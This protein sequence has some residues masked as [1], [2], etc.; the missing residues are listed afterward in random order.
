MGYTLSWKCKQKFMHTQT[1]AIDNS[2]SIYFR[3]QRNMLILTI[4]FWLWI[5]EFSFVYNHKKIVSAIIFFQ[6]KRKIKPN[7]LGVLSWKSSGSKW[8]CLRWSNCSPRIREQPF[9]ILLQPIISILIKFSF[10]FTN[11]HL[12]NLIYP[13]GLKWR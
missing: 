10:S 2:I 4:F 5:T 11:D 3:I 12:K 7:Y 6:F 9:P 1:I 8:T 13:N